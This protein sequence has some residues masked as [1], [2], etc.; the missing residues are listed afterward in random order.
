MKWFKF[1][2]YVQLILS[3][4]GNFVACICYLSGAYYG[5]NAELIYEV[6]PAME[7][8]DMGMALISLGLV[9]YAIVVRSYLARFKHSGPMLLHIFLGISIGTV[10]CYQVAAM[11]ITHQNL[12][13]ATNVCSIIVLIVMLACNCIYF[14]KRKDLFVK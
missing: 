13:V 14:G 11:M 12:I 9:A 7:V 10:L 5:E 6:F 4:I 8:L 3:A 2:I 1:T